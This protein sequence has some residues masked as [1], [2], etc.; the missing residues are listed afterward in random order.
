MSYGWGGDISVGDDDE[1]DLMDILGAV[2]LGDDYELGAKRKRKPKGTFT[3]IAPDRL[4]QLPLPITTNGLPTPIAAGATVQIR[5]TPQVPFK[6]KRIS[7]P[8]AGLLITDVLVGNAS[9]Y[10]S[11]GAI[12]TECFSPVATYVQ[13]KGDTA[14]PG[15]DIIVVVNNPT[16]A[17]VDFSG[18][19][20]GPV[21]QR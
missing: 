18:M 5:L 3:K 11:S 12:P 15:V 14:V 8:T 17:E 19:I 16:V 20:V 4:D 13:L 2:E 7:T 10:V 1:D 6:P 9:Q 21:A